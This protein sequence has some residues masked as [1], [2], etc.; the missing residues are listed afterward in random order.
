MFRRFSLRLIGVMVLAMTSRKLCI[1]ASHVFGALVDP[2]GHLVVLLASNRKLL[3]V[4]LSFSSVRSGML[5]VLFTSLYPAGY[6]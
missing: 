6:P 1:P 3:A 4:S 5:G 2:G